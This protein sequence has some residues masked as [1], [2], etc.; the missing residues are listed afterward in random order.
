MYTRLLVLLR[1]AAFDQPALQRALT[2]SSAQT[3]IVLLDAVYE[4][5]LEGY[6]GRRGRMRSSSCRRAASNASRTA[7]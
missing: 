7:T 3:E 5:A 1:D 4:P 6:M 2:L